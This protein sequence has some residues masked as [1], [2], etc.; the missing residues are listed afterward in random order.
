MLSAVDNIS[1][2]LTTPE[3]KTRINAFLDRKK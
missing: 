2:R 1:I 3:I